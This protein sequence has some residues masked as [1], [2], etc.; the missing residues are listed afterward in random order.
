MSRL[1]VEPEPES[2]PTEASHVVSVAVAANVWREYSYAWPQTLGAPAPGQRVRVGFGPGNRKTLGFVTSVDPPREKRK[3]KFV[4]E[5]IDDEP[6]LTAPLQ[7]LA[8]WISRYYL[9]PP[10]LTLSA[11]IPSS[12]SSA[13]GI[14]RVS[15]RISSRFS[16]RR[17]QSLPAPL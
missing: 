3:L 17:M 13:R 14:S 11:M 2:S 10:G 16:R 6:Q 5:T 7:K 4:S 12:T 8:E 1:F 15:L 9:C